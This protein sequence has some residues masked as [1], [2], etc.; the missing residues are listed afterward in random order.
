MSEIDRLLMVYKAEDSL[1]S[2]DDFQEKISA[3]IHALPEDRDDAIADVLLGLFL[4]AG[5]RVREI[6][7]LLD[8]TPRATLIDQGG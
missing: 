2:W 1:E 5:R 3:A 6:R 8:A 7:E 4:K